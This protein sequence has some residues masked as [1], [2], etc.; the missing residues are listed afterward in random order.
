MKL[1]GGD[2]SSAKFDNKI[3]EFIEILLFTQA[4]SQDIFN[5]FI[6][7]L[8]IS[9]YSDN[10]DGQ[11]LQIIKE[12]II[13]CEMSQQNNQYLK[14]PKNPCNPELYEKGFFEKRIK[15]II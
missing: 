4:Y 13:Q 8:E 7:F 14:L 10:L 1:K 9:K 5:L 2:I 11:I 3:D 12:N 6:I 15:Y